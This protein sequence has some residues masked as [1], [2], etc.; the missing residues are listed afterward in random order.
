M[1]GTVT[2]SSA[3]YLIANSEGLALEAFSPVD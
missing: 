1:G 2:L 3:N